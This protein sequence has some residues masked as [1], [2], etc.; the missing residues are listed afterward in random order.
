[1]TS[2]AASYFLSVRSKMRELGALPPCYSRK[3]RRTKSLDPV[4][5]RY[6][7]SMFEAVGTDTVATLEVHNPAAFENAF[8]CRTVTLTAAPIAQSGGGGPAGRCVRG[9]GARR[10]RLVYG[11]LRGSGYASRNRPSNHHR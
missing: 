11:R 6:V 1:M 5:T 9:P 8:R 7:A 10:A 2:C 3:D 4:T